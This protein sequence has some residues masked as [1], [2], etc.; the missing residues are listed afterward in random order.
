M[1]KYK[2]IEA[3]VDETK[4]YIE[5]KGYPLSYIYYDPNNQKS[6]KKSPI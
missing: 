1:L 5:D 3:L 2:V 4:K 6:D